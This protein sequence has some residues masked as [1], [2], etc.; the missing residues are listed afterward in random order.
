MTLMWQRLPQ[1]CQTKKC[2]QLCKQL[3]LLALL[4]LCG[5]ITKQNGEN[6]SPDDL[7]VNGCHR[8]LTHRFFVAKDL[9]P[10]SDPRKLKQLIG[11]IFRYV[12]VIRN[13]PKDWEDWAESLEKEALD[14]IEEDREVKRRKTI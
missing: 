1:I 11:G 9:D 6:S 13:Q 12:H 4:A 14:Q 3:A 8:Y 2:R 5:L 10:V 7:S